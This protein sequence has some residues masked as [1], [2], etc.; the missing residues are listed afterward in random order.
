MELLQ[1][2]CLALKA[3]LDAVQKDKVADLATYKQMFEEVRKIFY[4]A[5]RYLWIINQ[6]AKIIKRITI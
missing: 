2:E 3:R 4:E 6:N 5:Y 1:E